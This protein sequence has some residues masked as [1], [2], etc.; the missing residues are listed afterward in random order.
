MGKSLDKRDRE[1]EAARLGIKV[2][3]RNGT[4]EKFRKALGKADES[5]KEN[6]NG[7]R[8]SD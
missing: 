5:G 4:L 3:L 2:N 1:N 8:H 6:D 7:K